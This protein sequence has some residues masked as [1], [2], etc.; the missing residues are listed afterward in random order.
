MQRLRVCGYR[1]SVRLGQHDY[2]AQ[3]KSVLTDVEGEGQH[4]CKPIG[5][6]WEWH[7]ATS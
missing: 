6:R 3:S 4:A 2:A 5:D 7:Q 1:P